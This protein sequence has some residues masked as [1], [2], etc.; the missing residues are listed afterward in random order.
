M[1]V[2]QNVIV[3][4]SK[5]AIYAY[6]NSLSSRDLVHITNTQ[7]KAAFPHIPEGTIR[8]TKMDYFKQREKEKGDQI[9]APKAQKQ[10]RKKTP[11][12]DPPDRQVEGR[13]P[14]EDPPPKEI[15]RDLIESYIARGLAGLEVNAPL[16]S[17]ALKFLEM[18]EGRTLQSELVPVNDDQYE[19][20]IARL[21][22]GSRRA[23]PENAPPP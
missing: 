3:S 16:I 18:K 17:V 12:V 20:Y 13:P 21:T 6:L 5:D 7:L 4:C 14:P 2:P 11:L 9:L 1:A 23:N 15:T 19:D 8:R 10:T 22:N